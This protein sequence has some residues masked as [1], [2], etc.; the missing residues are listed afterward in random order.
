MFLNDAVTG[1]T[2]MTAG[3]GWHHGNANGVS[4]NRARVRRSMNEG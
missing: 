4:R 2:W 3:F 1:G